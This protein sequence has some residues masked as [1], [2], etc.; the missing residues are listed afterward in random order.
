MMGRASRSFAAVTKMLPRK[1]INLANLSISQKF[2]AAKAGWRGTPLIR[3]TWRTKSTAR[4]LRKV[5]LGYMLSW[6]CILRSGK[7]AL[8]QGDATW[9]LFTKNVAV[10][11][12][13]NPTMLY[14]NSHIRT[15]GDKE[16]TLS[17][18]TQTKSSEITASV[19]GG[20]RIPGWPALSQAE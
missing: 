12:V 11:S 13:D 10:H 7:F 1:L 9:H 16:H 2:C 19:H 15:S 3:S 18:A 20:A 8:T 5:S 4:E 14:T 17:L 6:F